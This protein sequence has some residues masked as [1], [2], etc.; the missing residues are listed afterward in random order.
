MANITSTA[1]DHSNN[2]ISVSQSTDSSQH[3]S[4]VPVAKPNSKNR[5][6]PKNSIKKINVCFYCETHI[7]SKISRHLLNVH[8]N[9]EEVKAIATL[10]KRSAE[11]MSRLKQLENEGNFKHNIKV[12]KNG[13]GQLVVGRRNDDSHAVKY[14]PC[15]HCRKFFSRRNLYRH[16]KT[17]SQMQNFSTNTTN[18]TEDCSKKRKSAVKAGKALLSTSVTEQNEE[19]LGTLFDRI[20]DDDVKMIV[21]SDHLIRHFATTQMESLGDSEIQKYNDINRVRQ[22]ARLLGR[23]VKECR[24]SNPGITLSDLITPSMFDLV[25]STA[26][27]MSLEKD[28]PALNV[29][30]N[31]GLLLGHIY[32]AKIALAIQDK[33]WSART[34]AKEFAW[35]LNTYWNKRVNSA[36]TKRINHEKRLKP[37]LIPDTEDLVKLRD[38]MMKKIAEHSS[39][40]S[41]KVNKEDW[42][43][44]CKVTMSRLIMF[45]RRRPAEVTELKV[46]HY[47]QRPKW[48]EEANREIT[49][50]L[51]PA[52]QIL[53]KR[54]SRLSFNAAICT[55]GLQFCS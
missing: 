21:Q 46:E 49:S 27:K 12:L 1:N 32:R 45:N 18:E 16:I 35:L 50:A 30:K 23:L 17:C 51:Q 5:C 3:T 22:P 40:L 47:L 9:E 7:S 43:Q 48:H 31:I 37:R 14:L 6:R 10:Q 4:T 38:F 34:D 15:E 24:V 20:S 13:E 39:N 28:K 2:K 11:R 42:T 44:L 55:S 41:N 52:D 33:D 25:V 19:I 36:A 29:G 26:K 53:A 54:Y 8:K